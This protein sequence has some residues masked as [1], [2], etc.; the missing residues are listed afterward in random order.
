MGEIENFCFWH[1]TGPRREF[2]S[3]GHPT[4][5]TWTPLLS[6]SVARVVRLEA[7]KVIGIWENGGPHP[8]ECQK[9]SIIKETFA[10]RG[11][12]AYSCLPL[13]VASIIAR[14][15]PAY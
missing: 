10:I 8:L 12:S 5:G 7:Y 1:L 13:T 6:S 14:D 9:T 4:N 3:G 15:G 11:S 2:S